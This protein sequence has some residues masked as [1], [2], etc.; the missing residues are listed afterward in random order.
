M[1]RKTIQALYFGGSNGTANKKIIIHAG[2]SAGSNPLILAKN[3][4]QNLNRFNLAKTFHV[5]C[6]EFKEKV[7]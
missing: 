6:V 4:F 1:K 5:L 2:V 3:I 7:K